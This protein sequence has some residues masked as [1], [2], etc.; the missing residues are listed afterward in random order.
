MWPAWQ[1]LK[2]G[3]KAGNHDQSHARSEGSADKEAK[4]ASSGSLASRERRLISVIKI[5]H[6]RVAMNL[7]MKARLSAK[8]LL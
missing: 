4:K 3:R 2:G 1:V 5:G 8:S 7:I 6:F